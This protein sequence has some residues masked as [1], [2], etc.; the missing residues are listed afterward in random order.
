MKHEAGGGGREINYHLVKITDSNL[1]SHLKI[2]F[3][4]NAFGN[5]KWEQKLSL[6]FS[7]NQSNHNIEV[8]LSSNIFHGVVIT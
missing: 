2:A 4:N 1:F 6:L 8:I 7:T 3:V 5:E